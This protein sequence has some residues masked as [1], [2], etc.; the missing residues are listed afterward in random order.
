MSTLGKILTFLNVLAAIGLFVLAGKNY[1]E[2]REARYRVFRHEIYLTGLP[3]DKDETVPGRPEESIAARLEPDAVLKDVFNGNDGGADLGG[4]PVRTVNEELDRVQKKVRDNV[5]AQP[6]LDQQRKKLR[7]YLLMQANDSG[8]REELRNV[9]DTKPIEEGLQKLDERFN[10]AKKLTAPATPPSR[11]LVRFAAARLFANLSF[12]EKWLERVRVVCGIEALSHGLDESARRVEQIVADVKD[13]MTRDQGD[14]VVR[15]RDL[16]QQ[17]KLDGEN[18]YQRET[19]LAGQKVVA[20]ERKQEVEQ[21]QTEVDRNRARLAELTADTNK[22]VA[23][24]E[25]IQKDL[26][27]IQ[28]RLSDALDAGRALEEQL[29]KRA[30]NKP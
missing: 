27:A 14:F 26:F 7:G 19:R 30:G 15:Y 16:L 28:Q 17:L 22:E 12:D 24:L 4:S 3:V 10:L 2:F 25:A 6:N 1:A 29:Q 21:R 23:R 5:L 20:A 18:I 9:I 8:E 11:L 13:A